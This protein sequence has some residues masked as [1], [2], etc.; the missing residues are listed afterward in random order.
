[1]IVLD[2]VSME[3]RVSDSN[4]R[5]DVIIKPIVSASSCR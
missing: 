5:Q 3:F 1:M 4:G 2:E